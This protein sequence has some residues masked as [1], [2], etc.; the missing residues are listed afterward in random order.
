MI[1]SLLGVAERERNLKGTAQNHIPRVAAAVPLARCLD[2]TMS[3]RQRTSS[4]ESEGKEWSRLAGLAE[5]PE[6]LAF[7]D[8]HLRRDKCEQC[9]FRHDKFARRET[10]YSERNSR[11]LPTPPRIRNAS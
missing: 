8:S 4:E 10:E 2:S 3:S 9:F 7:C 5:L 11:D 6:G 1:D